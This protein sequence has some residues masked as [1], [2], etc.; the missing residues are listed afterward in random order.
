MVPWPL[1]VCIRIQTCLFDPKCLFP[2]FKPKEDA[3]LVAKVLDVFDGIVI[4]YGKRE[5]RKGDG[6]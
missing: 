3:S 4:R 5:R 2:P 6:E 1:S